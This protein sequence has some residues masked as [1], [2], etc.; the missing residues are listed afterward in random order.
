MSAKL[1]HSPFYSVFFPPK[2][3]TPI[4]TVSLRQTYRFQVKPEQKIIDVPWVIFDLE[5]TG[6]SRESDRIIELGGMKYMGTKEVDH[7]STLVKVDRVIPKEVQKLTGINPAMLEGKPRISEAI[8]KFIEFIKGSVLIC[9]N[10]SFD[11]PMMEA[12]LSRQN[13]VLDY[14]CLCTLKMARDLLSDLPSKKLTSL[15]EHYQVAY[16]TQHRSLDDARVTG[17]VFRNM[18]ESLSLS[19]TYASLARYYHS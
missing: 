13:M 4:K 7:F 17:I 3:T 9:H 5:T 18:L 14:P 11:I 15:A 1:K 16:H 6:F 12:E 8:P 19:S 2:D 10:S